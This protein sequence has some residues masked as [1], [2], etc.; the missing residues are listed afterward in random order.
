MYYFTSITTNY[1]PKAR[2][3]AETLKRHNSNAKFIV[4]LCD[5]LPEEFDI[6]KEPFDDI[7]FADKLDRYKNANVFF[8][9]YN[10]TEICTAVKPGIALEIMDRYKA[11]KVVYLDPDIAVFSSMYEIDQL[12]DKYSMIFVPHSTVPDTYKQLIIG[13]EILFLKKGVFNLGFFAVKADD[14][15]RRFLNWWHERLFHYCLDDDCT[16]YELLDEEGRLGTFTDQKW[17][18]LVPCFFDN[19]HILKTPGYD[20]ATWN[21]SHQSLIKQGS[22][23]FVNGYPLRF[24]HFSSFDSRHHHSVLNLI[25]AVN[26]SCKDAV[27]LSEWYERELKKVEQDK[28]GSFE[29]KYARY[30]NGEKI[31]KMH[32]KILNIRQDV[33]EVFI[34]PFI[35]NAGQCYYN[36]VKGE[37]GDYLNKKCAGEVAVTHGRESKPYRTLKYILLRIFPQSSKFWDIARHIKKL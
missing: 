26:N 9:K 22:E 21:L 4:S 36:W 23:W 35:V 7:I 27:K 18:D 17:I 8:F 37:Y 28:L 1:I 15:G 34:D 5:D 30:S 6:S 10:V 32:R 2:I 29:W 16:L 24:Y 12:L 13:N 3:L 25:I 31:P 11:D 19:Y 20:V 33:H 14:E